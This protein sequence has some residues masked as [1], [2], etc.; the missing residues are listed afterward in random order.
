[1]MSEQLRFRE[2]VGSAA[3]TEFKKPANLDSTG[4]IQMIRRGPDLCFL[5]TLG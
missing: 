3:T 5:L 1:L 2:R 4:S